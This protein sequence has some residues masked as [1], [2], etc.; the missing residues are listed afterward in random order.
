MARSSSTEASHSASPLRF[1]QRRLP[2]KSSSLEPEFGVELGT[3]AI[4]IVG[5]VVGKH[6][7]A[8]RR[9]A[10]GL[11]DAVELAHLLDVR[12]GGADV[13]VVVERA[14]DDAAKRAVAVEPPPLHVGERERVH[15]PGNDGR[16]QPELGGLAVPHGRTRNREQRGA[17]DE[18]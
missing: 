5:L 18:K 2:H 6:V 17:G 4:V 13:P 14:A 9:Q 11:A 15:S 12:G 3:L 1:A 10:L 8:Q 16:G 7:D